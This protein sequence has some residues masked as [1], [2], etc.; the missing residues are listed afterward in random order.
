MSSN[1]SDEVE[2]RVWIRRK[3]KCFLM[4]SGYD[5]VTHHYSEKLKNQ[6][7]LME[8]QASTY[9]VS[10][11]NWMKFISIKTDLYRRL[12]TVHEDAVNPQPAL[13]QC[14]PSQF[15]IKY[16]ANQQSTNRNSM[17]QYRPQH[18]A[19]QYH[20][21]DFTREIGQSH[22]KKRSAIQKRRPIRHV[23]ALRSCNEQV[24][25]Y[26]GPTITALL[27]ENIEE[28]N[29]AIAIFIDRPTEYICPKAA[30][31]NFEAAQ[32]HRK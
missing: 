1:A 16:A 31:T 30:R 29:R 7:Q 24:R 21:K 14:Q 22:S 26:P 20:C 13:W 3:T 10:K 23:C 27:T 32:D 12:W 5:D 19:I 15:L 9:W 6:T 17:I 25:L 4:I 8:Q 18:H 28:N 11:E 2:H